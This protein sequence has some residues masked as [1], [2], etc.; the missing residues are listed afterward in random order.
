[1]SRLP[2]ISQIFYDSEKMH[3]S[4]RLSAYQGD[5]A[6]D[7]QSASKVM[8]PYI[9]SIYYR[10]KTISKPEVSEVDPEANG[11]KSKGFKVKTSTQELKSQ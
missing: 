1:M 8:H 10:P 4:L 3:I 6:T 5:T 11:S 9:L 2:Y 7:F